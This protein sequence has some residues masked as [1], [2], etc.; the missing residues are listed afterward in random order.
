MPA[1]SEPY[2]AK[3]IAQVLTGML[4]APELHEIICTPPRSGK[5]S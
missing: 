3:R 2:D 1:V 4:A 5:E